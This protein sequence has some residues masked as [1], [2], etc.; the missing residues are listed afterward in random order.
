MKNFEVNI[1]WT[2]TQGSREKKHDIFQKRDWKQRKKTKC[3]LKILHEK[4]KLTRKTGHKK[5]KNKE[6][7]S[8]K[9]EIEESKVFL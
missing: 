3:F 9:K 4:T 2:E 1:F 6:F 8:W 7:S 5:K